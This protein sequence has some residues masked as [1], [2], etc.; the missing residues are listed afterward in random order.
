MWLLPCSD[1][2]GVLQ[3]ESLLVA[4]SKAANGLIKSEDEEDKEAAKR[5]SSNVSDL[6]AGNAPKTF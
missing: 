3:I 2:H 5:L 1:Q 4:A 6:F